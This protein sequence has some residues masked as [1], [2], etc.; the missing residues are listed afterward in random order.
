ME[1]SVGKVLGKQGGGV[2]GQVHDFVPDDVNKRDR[3]GRLVAVVGIEGGSDE[4]EMVAKGR[5]ILGRLHELYFGQ[6]EGEAFWLLKKAVGQVGEEFLGVEVVAL[7]FLG[8]GVMAA[9]SGEAGLWVKNGEK[10]GWAIKLGQKESGVVAVY[11]ELSEGEVLVAGNGKFWESVP[12]GTLR[13]AVE[14]CGSGMEETVEMLGAVEHGSERGTG[15]VG[16]IVNVGKTEKTE[17]VT[18]EEE[19]VELK[20]KVSARNLLE[21]LGD[22][23]KRPEERIYLDKRGGGISNK[24][25]VVVAAVFLGILM[26]VVVG[27]RWRAMVVEKG[28]SVTE[29]Q[30]AQLML[31]FREAQGVVAMNPVRAREVLVRVKTEIKDL[32]NNK[33]KDARLSEVLSGMDEVWG[34]AMGVV[35]TN[36]EEVTDLKLVR[37][38]V[39]VGKMVWVDGKLELL[40]TLGMRLFEVDVDKK[41]V[42]LVAGGGALG[43]AAS[44]AGYPGKVEVVADKGIVECVIADSACTTKIASDKTWKKIV[45]VGMFGGNVYLLDSGAETIWRYQVSDSGYGVRQ[46]WLSAGE[47]VTG[48]INM[49]ID[50]SIWVWADGKILKYTRGVK[51]NFEVTGLDKNI[52]SSAVVFTSEDTDRLYVLD[53]ENSRIVVI[54]KSGEYDKQLVNDKLGQMRDVVADGNGRVFVVGETQVWEVKK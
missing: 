26:V 40:D 4:M 53:K 18:V 37:D 54:K 19:K 47:K 21:M 42:S 24:R 34:M 11:G 36:L 3:L 8:R 17:V 9:R 30:L 46:A 49:A 50:G 52:G 41:S 16:V 20:E 15:G 6:E 43:K 29:K 38:G 27:G 22:K 35:T 28:S 25:G 7:V 48:G 2:W 33:V 23:F 10:E 32:Q 44:L 45:D 14:N 12:M 51:E 39:G 1:L 31:D 13:A 5:E